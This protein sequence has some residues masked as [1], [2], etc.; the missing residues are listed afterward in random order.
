[1]GAERNKIPNA[2]VAV[3]AT[4]QAPAQSIDDYIKPHVR[5]VCYGRLE[6]NKSNLLTSP[7]EFYYLTPRAHEARK[8]AEIV[9][10]KGTDDASGFSQMTCSFLHPILCDK[11]GEKRFSV[12]DGEKEFQESGLGALAALPVAMGIMQTICVAVEDSKKKQ[13]TKK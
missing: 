9:S 1:M 2:G 5:K 3:R 11:K 6:P 8:F 7:I 12:E 10:S 13:T 4:S